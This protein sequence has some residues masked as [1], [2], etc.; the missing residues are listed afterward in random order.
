MRRIADA[1]LLG[2]I[3]IAGAVL[4]FGGLAVPSLWLDEI[5]DYD[6]AT[7]LSHEPLWRWLTSFDSEHGPLFFATELAGRVAQTPEMAAR[8]APALFGVA[9]IVVAWIAGVECRESGVGVQGASAPT[10]DPR[11]SI[12]APVF[13]LLLA[14]SPLAIYYSREARPY[15]LLMLLATA[16]LAV[17][18]RAVPGHQGDAVVSDSRN[19]AKTVLIIAIPL[20]ALFAT[21]G[22]TPLLIAAALTASIAFL[23]VRRK[24][25]VFFAGAAVLAA[26]L[27]PLLYRRM[28]GA[29]AAAGFRPITSRFFI[30]LLQSFSV[31]A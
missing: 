11:L 13:A 9:A 10:P 22:A 24:E 20:L 31:S 14:G 8:L 30:R 4:R 29:S 19:R 27:V 21:S 25:F 26:A 1:L 5:L 12:P 18:L 23:L 7:K 28:P 6:V 15:A 2:A 16:M 17:L 3:V